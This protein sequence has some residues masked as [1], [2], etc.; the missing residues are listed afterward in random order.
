[1]DTVSQFLV[2]IKNAKSAGKDKV[3]VP[4]SRMRQN[5]AS[6]LKDKGWIKDFRIAEDGK[7]GLMRVYLGAASGYR[8][9]FER[10]S[11]PG[12]RVYVTADEIASVRSGKG[13][14]IVSTNK[15]IMT[16]DRARGQKIGGELMCKI[17]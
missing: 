6:I 15:G 1:M 11:R 8:G 13:F 12:R 17:W 10:I 3:D 2:S 5:I 7:Q 9:E 16:D 14:S 4:S